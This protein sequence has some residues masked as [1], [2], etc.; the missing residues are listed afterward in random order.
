[1]RIGDVGEWRGPVDH[2][3]QDA[4]ERPDVA[5]SAE[6]ENDRVAKVFGIRIV[7]LIVAM[8]AANV[9]V[10]VDESFG[11]HVV[12]RADLVL[13]MHIHRV[14]LDRVGDTKIDNLQPA[15]DDQEIGRLEI[16]VHDAVFVDGLHTLQHLTP[17]MT[18]EVNV[19]TSRSCSASGA[20]VA[21]FDLQVQHPVEIRLAQFHQHL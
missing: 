20:D 10:A 1:M 9:A 12:R 4:A 7:V 11:T 5:G 16:R 3:I 21:P 15:L 18:G 8:V 6:F 19:E 14:I 2:L 17:V 13:P